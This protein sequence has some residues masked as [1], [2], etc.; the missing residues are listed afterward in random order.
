MVLCHRL[1]FIGH[2]VVDVQNLNKVIN[3]SVIV[4]AKFA[5]KCVPMIL[6]VVKHKTRTLRNVA[7]P[8]QNQALTQKDVQQQVSA[9]AFLPTLGKKTK[10]WVI[11]VQAMIKE[12]VMANLVSSLSS[13]RMARA[14]TPSRHSVVTLYTPKPASVEIC[15]VICGLIGD[16]NC[17]QRLHLGDNISERLRLQRLSE[18]YAGNYQNFVVRA[19]KFL[20]S[21]FLF[22]FV[23]SLKE[24]K[25][26]GSKVQNFWPRA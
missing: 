22:G 3:C 17:A 10:H 12:A 13:G 18:K 2:F 25:V 15:S 21:N 7:S 5:R 1:V 4:D 20:P 6:A 23:C 24:L 9:N 14:G 16:F 19:K 11:V 26:K 8:R